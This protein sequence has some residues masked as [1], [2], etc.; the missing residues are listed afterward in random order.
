MI[1]YFLSDLVALLHFLYKDMWTAQKSS[2]PINHILVFVCRKMNRYLI[3]MMMI[4]M[5][6]M[7]IMI[8]ILTLLMIIMIMIIIITCNNN[9]NLLLNNL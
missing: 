8:M 7:M 2:L 6:M 5:M 1:N 3:K 4:M 9:N